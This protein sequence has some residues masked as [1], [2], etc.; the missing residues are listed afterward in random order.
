MKT[1]P[2]LLIVFAAF[3]VIGFEALKPKAA[4]STLLQKYEYS[5]IRWAGR[6][7]THLIRPNSQ[8]EMLGPILN[9]VQRPDRADERA[10]YMAVAM[11]AVAKEGYEFAGMTPDEIVMKRPIG[12]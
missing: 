1:R 10:F 3:S 5:T 9:R 7:N 2:T 11:N 6:D 4:D 8:V 12:R